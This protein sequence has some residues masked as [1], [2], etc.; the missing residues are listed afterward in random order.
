MAEKHSGFSSSPSTSTLAPFE[1]P[2]LTDLNLPTRILSN[3]ANLEEYRHETS[4]GV[5]LQTH[6]RMVD[7][8]EQK[9]HY[10]LVTFT[11]H[12]PENPKNWSKAMK[13]WCTLIISLVCFTVAF[14][15]AVI[16]AD[17]EGV[18]KTFGVSNEVSFLTIT[19]FVVGF[20]IGNV[21]S[22]YPSN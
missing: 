17:I 16:T 15:S 4:T 14:C 18:S 12:D 7:G 22:I 2:A 5:I 11:E 9:V 8:H 13:W 3:D 6:V 20:G 1:D 19:L 21:V 10:K